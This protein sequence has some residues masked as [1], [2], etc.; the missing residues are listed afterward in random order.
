[1]SASTVSITAN[2][3]SRRRPLVVGEKKSTTDLA[4]DGGGGGPTM[5]GGD[6]KIASASRDLSYSLRGGEAVIERSKEAVT[7]KKTVPSSTVSPRRARKVS[8]KPEKP[9]WLTV[10][11]VITKNFLLIVVIIGLVQMI[12][13]LVANSGNLS[14]VPG[15][16]SEYESRIAEV[17][18]FVKTATKMMQVQVEVVDRKIESEVGGL[19][20]ELHKKID[21]KGA[22][23]EGELQK[24]DMRTELLERISSEL[25]ARDMFTKEDFD[26]FYNELKKAE[27]SKPVNK[28]LSLDDVRAVARDIVKKEIER[29][30]A[31]GLGRVDYAVASG[32]AFVVRHSEPFIGG[33]GSLWKSMTAA[34]TG[35]HV[36]AVRM[37]KPSFGEP[38]QCFPLKGSTGFVEIRLRTAIVPEAITVEHVSKAVAY[39]L[40]T[41]PKDCRVFGWLQGADAVD[42][43]DNRILLAEFS[44]DL[45]KSSAQTFSVLEAVGSNVIN[46]VRLELASNHGN[47]SLTCIYR[48][49]VHGYEPKSITAPI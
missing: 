17:E 19:R 32:G 45:E 14:V 40:S 10:I 49:R 25:R 23:L 9:R 33:K 7:V 31:D 24:M 15:D 8:Q 20:R 34:Q 13:K 1:M 47:L 41:A 12:R 46:T 30:A 42:H 21:E 35:V 5:N 36:D 38:G 44:Y 29:H 3:A 18:A 43:S 39:D 22:A 37:L 26:K 27:K 2:T 6:D 16:V 28:E 48:L 4:T 11:R